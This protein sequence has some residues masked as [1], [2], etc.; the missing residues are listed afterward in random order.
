MMYGS[1]ATSGTRVLKNSNFANDQYGIAEDGTNGAITVTGTYFS[2]TAKISLSDQ[3][4]TI[5]NAATSATANTVGP[6][7]Q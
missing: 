3:E 4:V 1:S 2:S 6:R 5:S 7:A